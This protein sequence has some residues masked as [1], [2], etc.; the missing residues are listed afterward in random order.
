MGGRKGEGSNYNFENIQ[1]S[2]IETH[3]DREV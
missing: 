2:L 3:K 1:G